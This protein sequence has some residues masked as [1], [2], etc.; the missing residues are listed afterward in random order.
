MIRLRS[1]GWLLRTLVA[2][3]VVA[4]A[5]AGSR[6]AFGATRPNETA[7]SWGQSI[8]QVRVPGQGCY[9]ASYPTLQWHVT[10]CEVAP[11]LPM[12][13]HQPGM[14]A[15]QAVGN[16]NDYAAEVSGTISQATGSFPIVSP[17][18]I[19]EK[20]QR[21]HKGPQ[22]PNTFTLQLN[23]EFFTTPVCSGRDSKCQGW[24]QF[25]YETTSSTV[26][27]QYWLLNYDTTCPTGW[28][29]V[30][31]GSA[32]YCYTNSSASSLPGNALTAAGLATVELQ[33]QATADG[34][35]QVSM[36]VGSGQ[37]TLVAN[38]D[39]KLDLSSQ[40]DATEFGVFGDGGGG[41]A[42]FGR[43]TTLEAQTSLVTTNESAPTCVNDGF[44]AETN[45]LN[46]TVTPVIGTQ[47]SPTM[48]SEQTKKRAK[49]ASCA[50]AAG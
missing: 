3:C 49:T 25:I 5:A 1:S 34:N 13:P 22:V 33:G 46:L 16:G 45:N 43:K 4:V 35:D 8:K 23:S 44:T 6:A 32:I 20:G 11:N 40:W 36:S 26:F 14:S 9:H 7:A 48:V 2:I 50:T 12:A 15:S 31:Y 37:A 19:T 21:G 27:M 42:N 38:S 10:R 41:Q 24:Q 39:S 18:R 28:H 17:T 47:A 29:T 30:M